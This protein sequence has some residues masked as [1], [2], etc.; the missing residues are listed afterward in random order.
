MLAPLW[1]RPVLLLQRLEPLASA[2]GAL[3]HGAGVGAAALAQAA[4]N[5]AHLLLAIADRA[6][7][8]LAALLLQ[9]GALLL[10]LL[11]ALQQLLMQQLRA[12]QQGR[13][14]LGG[15]LLALA[16]VFQPGD[17]LIHLPFTAR[18]QQLLGFLQHG[19]IEAEA[20]GDRQGVAAAGDAP[21]QVV[22]GREGLHIE[23]H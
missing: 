10:L 16:L 22:G 1:H 9:F 19:A 20:A 2:P 18:R 15:L 5:A 3:A 11:P 13:G 8:L 4:D 7:Q 17:H 14:L 23:R 12:G 6:L 21:L